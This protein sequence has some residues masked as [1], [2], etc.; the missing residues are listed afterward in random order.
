MKTIYNILDELGIEYV[1]HEH[2]AVFTCEESEAVGY[3]R[4]EGGNTKNLFLRNKKGTRHYLV[5][6]GHEKQ[7][8]LK[9]L[10][11]KLG[12][13]NL[14]FASAERLMEY[15]GLTP[16]SVSLLGLVNNAAHDVIVILDEDLWKNNVICCHPNIN[17][18]TL[19]IKRE[20]MEK[21]FKWC[22]NEVRVMEL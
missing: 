16:G 18:S 9:T 15:L 7:A 21:F 4:A 1:K 12:E 8:D 11:E 5:S 17:T 19:D 22:G 14:S 13:S 2:P 3:R 20:D 6:L 10:K